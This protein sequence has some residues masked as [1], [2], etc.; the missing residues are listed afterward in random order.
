MLWK[1]QELSISGHFCFLNE[2]ENF[3]GF[4]EEFLLLPDIALLFAS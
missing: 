3:C 1:F 4:A 2:K